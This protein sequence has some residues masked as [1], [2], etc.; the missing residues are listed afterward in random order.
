MPDPHFALSRLAEVYDL[1]NPWTRDL[2]FYLALARSSGRRVLDLGCGT[3]TLACALAERGHEVT[4]VD[5]AAAMLAVARTKPFAERVHWVEASAQDFQS[6]ERFDLAVMTGH[7]LQVFLTDA[8]LLAV[9]RTAR[10]HLA[11]GGRVAFETRNPRVDWAGEWAAQ[12]PK[13]QP[14]GVRRSLENISQQGELIS[15]EQQYRFADA[16]IQSA[17]TLRF[18]SRALMETLLAR[19]GLRLLELFGEWDGSA[20][21]SSSSR[22]MIYVAGP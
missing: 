5:P 11:E 10:Q 14:G 1:D 3:G 12:A 9:F 13:E 2:D 20:F 17:S 6:P 19:A 22:E 8:D 7:T 4:G 15:F 21:D 18:P 16:T